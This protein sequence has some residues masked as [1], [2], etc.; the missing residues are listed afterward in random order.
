MTGDEK[1]LSP[2]LEGETPHTDG[3]MVLTRA[4]LL[5]LEHRLRNHLNAILMTAAALALQC[6]PP[7]CA[8]A[9][10]DQ[11][12]AEVQRCLDLLRRLVGQAD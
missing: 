1:R 9:Y 2:P 7:G 8:D 10:L 12:D 4:E 5:A 3:A 6:Q 11:M